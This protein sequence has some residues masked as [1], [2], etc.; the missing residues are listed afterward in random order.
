MTLIIA[1]FALIAVIIL[2]KKIT[3]ILGDYINRGFDDNGRF[4]MYLH[5]LKN[6]LS[7]PIFGGG[8]YSSYATEH[9]F[10]H[11]L[12]YRYHNTLIQMLATCGIF[13]FSSYLFHRFQTV[14]LFISKK[15]ISTLFI[16][17]CIGTMLLG[18]LL[19]NHFFNIYPAIIY[20]T[21]LMAVEKTI[22]E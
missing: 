20:S 12:P 16:A 8:F 2:W 5:G 1:F 17:L 6:F 10:I 15:K 11:F 4:E 18:S 7:H 21:M 9:M 22:Y 19:D 3:G 13:G 14:K